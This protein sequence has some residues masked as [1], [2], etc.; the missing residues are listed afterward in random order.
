[1]IEHTA[2]ICYIAEFIGTAML[3]LIGISVCCNNSLNKSG[4]KGAG[5]VL[6]CIGWGLAVML[7]AVIF[8]AES[9]AHFN[10]ALTIALAA[11]G[12]IS[13]E[14]VPGYIVCQFAGAFVGAIIAYVLFKDHFDATDD[15]DVK[16]GVFCTKP[17][18]RNLPRNMLVEI[19]ATFILVFTIEGIGAHSFHT[20]V[21]ALYTF[22]LIVGIGMAVGGLTGFAINP[23]R[24]IGP[25]LAHF[26]LP[27]KGKRDS[28]WQYAIV[29]LVGPIIGALLAVG[30]Y[31]ILPW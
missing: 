25:R 29:P 26:I 13:W 16:L 17:S 28:D 5:P 1:M 22:G 24:D 21:E 23:A 2:P 18:I 4:M 10:P 20:G 6:V 15:A 3:L 14:I 11:D 19:V 9:G 31:G 7:P 12:I 8:G 27:I 30:L